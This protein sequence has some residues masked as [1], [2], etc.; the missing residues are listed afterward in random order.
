MLA[1]FYVIFFGWVFF[2][3]LL[4]FP[5][6]SIAEDLGI[7]LF[8]NTT[9]VQT[10][11]TQAEL[12]PILKLM[13]ASPLAYVL[14][15]LTFPAALVG[16]YLGQ[17]LIHSR[18]LR[19]LHTAAKRFR[20]IRVLQGFILTWIVLGAF[21]FVADILGLIEIE[22]VFSGGK[23]WIYALVSPLWHLWG[24]ISQTLKR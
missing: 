7:S 24:Y 11:S 18:T 6:A 17:K 21:A 13:G 14:F 1:V 19:S 10:D 16:L 12:D 23:F 4:S 15:L 9:D 2:S 22:Y 5:L 3:T 20:I 8:E